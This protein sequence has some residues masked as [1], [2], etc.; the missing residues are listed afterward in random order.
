MVIG[1]SS[2][3]SPPGPLAAFGKERRHGCQGQLRRHPES[4][5]SESM[6]MMTG[7]TQGLNFWS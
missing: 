3:G 5:R 7:G 4:Y 6:W 2:T 1:R